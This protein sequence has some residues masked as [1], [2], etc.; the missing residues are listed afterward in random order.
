MKESVKILI[1]LGSILI[2][3]GVIIQFVPT[4]WIGK[5]PGD[6][7]IEKEKFKL[8]IPIATSILISII[9]SLVLYLVIKSKL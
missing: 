4:N 9:L 3:V 1:I 8:Y 7:R 2:L 6:L 5:L